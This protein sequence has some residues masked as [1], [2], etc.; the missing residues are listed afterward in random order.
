MKYK[1]EQMEKYWNRKLENKRKLYEEQ[2]NQNEKTILKMQLNLKNVQ[3]QLSTSCTVA[4]RGKQHTDNRETTGHTTKVN[5]LFLF[6]LMLSLSLDLGLQ[7]YR[8]DLFESKE[9]IV[10][11][12]L[13]SIQI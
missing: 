12:E 11:E 2:I 9:L 5:N 10:R 8:K 13:F 6:S 3:K 7:E 1:F 4:R